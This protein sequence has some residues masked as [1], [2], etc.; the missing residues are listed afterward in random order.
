MKNKVALILSVF[1]IMISCESE[2]DNEI[3]D[4]SEINFLEEYQIVDA[5]YGTNTSVTLTDDSRVIRTNALPNHPT[6]DFPNSGNPHAISEQSKQYVLPL[7]P[8]FSGES[9]WAREPGIAVNGIKFEPE[10]AEQFVCESGEIYKIEAFQ[11]FI[12]L[13]FDLNQAHVQPT[14]EYHY[15][16]VPTELMELIKNGE[17]VILV[18]FAKD[19]FP[20]YY[21]VSGAYKPSYRISDDLRTGENCEYRTTIEDFNNTE[22]DGTFVSDWVYI[23]GLGQL[24]ECNGIELN[25]QYGYFITD[26]YPY[27]SRCLKGVFDEAPLGPAPSHQHQHPHH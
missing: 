16:G 10:T 21:S 18:G 15:H 26:E 9:T 5:T 22:P 8:T 13:G 17:D 27:V 19:G 11:D 3:I 14:G 4:I 12:N 20:I 1:I 2:D 7:N 25:G 24:D 6:G 23:E